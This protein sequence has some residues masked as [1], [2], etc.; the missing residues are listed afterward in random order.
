MSHQSEWLANAGKLLGKIEEELCA[1]DG[2][3]KA[4]PSAD[5]K[6]MI[7]TAFSALQRAIGP[8][9]ASFVAENDGYKATLTKRNATFLFTIMQEMMALIATGFKSR[10]SDQALTIA[11]DA[12]MDLFMSYY[13]SDDD[14]PASMEDMIARGR[15]AELQ[16]LLAASLKKAAQEEGD[17]FFEKMAAAAIQRSAAAQQTTSVLSM[18]NDLASVRIADNLK[19]ASDTKPAAHSVMLAAN[20]I[21]VDFGA[22]RAMDQMIANEPETIAQ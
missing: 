13:G 16:S 17:L 5:H 14:Y 11:N 12:A 20:V 18:F 19:D 15:E 9:F 8:L 22:S 3:R 2:A 4:D 1:I 6:D 10:V 7:L 21:K